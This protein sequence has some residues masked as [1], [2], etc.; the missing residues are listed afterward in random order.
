M[1]G[2]KESLEGQQALFDQ[3]G[4]DDEDDEEDSEDD[5]VEMMDANED[6]KPSDNDSA[7]D[8]KDTEEDEASDS[9]DEPEDFE[10]E[11]TEEELARLNKALAQ[12]VGTKPFNEGEAGQ[13]DDSSSDDAMNDDEM[14]ALDDKMVK[15]FKERRKVSNKKQEMKDARETIVNFKNRVL[16]LLEIYIKLQHQNKLVLN[17]VLPLLTLIRTSNSKQIADR[18]CGLIRDL[19]HRCKGKDV[20][21]PKKA[22]HV[23]D[24]LDEVHEEAMRAA[25][26][27]HAI[28]CSQ[29]SLL[30]GKVLVHMDG[31]NIETVV[32]RYAKTQVQW[33]KGNGRVQPLL[34]ADF[35]NWSSSYSKQ[36]Q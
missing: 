21:Q 22:R 15:V 9:A 7:T 13:D 16:D 12:I 31:D 26:K 28:A 4:E 36:H 19:T 29:S 34:F 3:G 27:A 10:A 20:P 32:E 30:L 33:L 2:T 23:R 8:A 25:S 17:L 1:L 18:S 11:G 35:L 14:F 24:M 6:A 5:D